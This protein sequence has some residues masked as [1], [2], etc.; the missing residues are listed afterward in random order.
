M[1]TERSRLE[2]GRYLIQ[3]A[4]HTI[5]WASSLQAVI[6]TIGGLSL[7][8]L[9]AGVLRRSV[10][11]GLLVAVG[12][13]VVLLLLG[14]YGAWR[15]ADAR[16]RAYESDTR[17]KRG[18]AASI[19]DARELR[20]RLRGVRNSSVQDVAVEIWSWSGLDVHQWLDDQMGADEL[21]DEWVAVMPGV[22]TSTMD[23]FEAALGSLARE[24][25]SDYLDVG[26]D[27]LLSWQSRLRDQ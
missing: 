3:V 20:G 21:A 15:D 9:I 26:I 6:G 10:L 19:R 16:A 12:L 23:E 17:L 25:L 13:T 8:P 22:S 1:T 18:L 7:L 4:R 24:R 5:P 11:L 14:S 2:L 27:Q